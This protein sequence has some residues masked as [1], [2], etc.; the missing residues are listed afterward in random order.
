VCELREGEIQAVASGGL[1]SRW[2]RPEFAVTSGSEINV[3]RPQLLRVNSDAGRPA[4]C[5]RLGRGRSC[6]ADHSLGSA[7]P[8]PECERIELATS[9]LRLALPRSFQRRPDHR[10]RHG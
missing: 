2:T 1:T 5:R 9:A 8:R 7:A 6:G 3:T 4:M 10:I